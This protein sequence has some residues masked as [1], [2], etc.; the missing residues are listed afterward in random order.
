M[1]GIFRS[2]ALALTI[3]L[4][5]CYPPLTAE[6]TSS[7]APKQLT[8]DRAAGLIDLR[9]AAGSDRLLPADAARLRRLAALGDIAPSDRVRVAAGGGPVLAAARVATIGAELLPYGIIVSPQ[10]LVAAPANRA[11]VDTGRYLVT[12]PPCPN[13]SRKPAVDLSNAHPSNFGCA[14]AVNLG[15]LVAS[16]ADLVRGRRGGPVDAIPATAAVQRYQQDKVVLPSTASLTSI[17]GGGGGG[18]TPGGGG[19]SAPPP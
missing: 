12:T 15:Q 8:L 16:P 13:W 1:T 14:T 19:G 2:I 4:G 10:P 18:G 17:G 11:I 7:E 6:W 3:V 9:F 5:G